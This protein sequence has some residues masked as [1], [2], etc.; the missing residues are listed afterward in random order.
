MAIRIERIPL[1]AANCYVVRDQGTILID[2]GS[3]GQAKQV[4]N[5][6]QKG[7]RRI[8]PGHG[9]PF[10]AGVLRNKLSR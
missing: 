2:G 10:D 1:L 9:K 8:H 3:P 5:R 4:L 6:L 7:A